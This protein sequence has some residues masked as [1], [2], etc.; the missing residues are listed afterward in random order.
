VTLTRNDLGNIASAIRSV[1]TADR[2]LNEAGLGLDRVINLRRVGSGR[3]VA[4]LVGTNDDTYAFQ[5]FPEA[6]MTPAEEVRE[7]RRTLQAVRQAVVEAD[8]SDTPDW[9]EAVSIIR[10]EVI[11]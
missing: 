1:M 11:P 5:G 7:L 2:Y 9:E 6:Q 8:R 3:Y 10:E 4:A